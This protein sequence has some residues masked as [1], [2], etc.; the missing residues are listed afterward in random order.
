M[1]CVQKHLASRLHYD[2]RLEHRGVL[3]SW[4][5]PKGPSL[6]PQDKRLCVRVEDHPFDYGEFEGVIPSG[7]GAGVVMLWD[8]GTWA[9]ESESEDVDRAL[10][11]GQLK[12]KLDGTKLKGSWALVRLKDSKNWLMI[13]H[14]D[15]WAGP[16]DIGTFAPDSVKTGGSMADIL[17]RDKEG[18]E[19]LAA[20]GRGGES[21]KML[22]DIIQEARMGK[23]SKRAYPAARWIGKNPES[24]PH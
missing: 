20:L 6:N 14:K 18:I 3:L 8:L 24:A 22:N 11:A 17:K 1:F 5:V 15:E 4:A 10:N 21:G 9:P 13:K 23:I 19:E 7:Y 12:F 2:F 16:I